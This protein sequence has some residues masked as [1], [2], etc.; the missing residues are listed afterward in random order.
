MQVYAGFPVLTNQPAEFRGRPEL[1]D[2]VG[3][4]DPGRPMS[5]AEYAAMA[6]PLVESEWAS[7]GRRWWSGAAGSTCVRRL[8]P[9]RP[10]APGD[11][12]RRGRLEE[13]ARDEGPEALHAELARL[14]PDAAAAIDHRNVRR[15]IRALE[16]LQSGGGRWSGRDDLWEP[17]YY[18]PTLDRRAVDGAERAREADPRAHRE[19]ARHGAVEEVRR[20]RAERGEED[21]R[22]GGPGICSAI[23]Y[24]EIWRYLDGEQGR[25]E[26]VEQ[27]AAA[28]RRYARRQITWL[29][30]V[31]DAVMIEVKGQDTG[32][33][34]REI[35]ALADDVAD[36]KEPCAG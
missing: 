26:T 21:A 31:R 23:G 17:D 11:A 34:A 13:R 16:G 32:E 10:P 2:L 35:A 19:D 20:F 12:E 24:G 9:W 14:D 8:R 22:P 4:V 1:H 27:I 18:H 25:A 29:R 36:A 5:A 28:T 33:I 30:K 15:V 7:A 6:R 3:V